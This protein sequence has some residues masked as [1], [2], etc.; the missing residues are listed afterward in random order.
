[1][2][3]CM[4]EWVGGSANQLL[5]LCDVVVADVQHLQEGEECSCMLHTGEGVPGH[6]QL[7]ERPQGRQPL[8]RPQASILQGQHLWRVT[9]AGEL[10]QCATCRD[11]PASKAAASSCHM[12]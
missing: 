11:S 10:K 3:S 5:P 12:T 1:M 2:L 4:C 7:L 8:Q 6:M 9:G